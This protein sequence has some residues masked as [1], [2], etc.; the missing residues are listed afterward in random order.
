MHSIWLAAIGLGSTYAGISRVSKINLNQDSISSKSYSLPRGRHY[1]EIL[2]Y[3]I[4]HFV[5][6]S[7]P[8]VESR[9]TKFIQSLVLF[10]HNTEACR[11]LTSPSDDRMK[12]SVT[13]TASVLP[14]LQSLRRIH[15]SIQLLQLRVLITRKLRLTK[16]ECAPNNST[17]NQSTIHM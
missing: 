9:L 6:S 10:T 15:L 1:Y 8:S 7:F 3:P 11:V 5:I 12:G 2:L 4:L 13:P 16:Q 14:I 17:L